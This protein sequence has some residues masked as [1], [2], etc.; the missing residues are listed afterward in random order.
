MTYVSLYRK[1]RS[2][3]FSDVMGQEHVTRT[4]QNAIKAQKIGHA[5]LFCGSRGTGKTTVARLLAKALNCEKGPTPE[6]CNECEACRAITDGTAVDVIEMD[7]ASH[8]SVDDIDALRDGVKYPPMLLRYKVYIIDEAHQLS[9]T[10]KDAF[11]KTL[12]E[13]PAHAVFILATTEAHE[14]P[15]TIRSRCQQFDFRRGTLQDISA[16]LRFVAESE[17]ASIDEEAVDTIARA[18]AGSWRDGLSLLEQVMAF[19]DQRITVR[20]VN[21]VLGTVERETL[22]EVADC[23]A[24]KDAAGAF[25]LA[26]KLIGE[27]RDVRELLRAIAGHFRDLLYAKARSS[28]EGPGEDG[29]YAARLWQQES[30]FTR[31]KL[32]AAVEIFSE[33]DRQTKWSDQHR[34]LLEMALLRAMEETMPSRSA[35]QAISV[36]EQKKPGESAARRPA[37]PPEPAARGARPAPAAPRRADER[38]AEQKSEGRQAE[39]QPDGEVTI[40]EVHSGWPS[41]V[42]IFKGSK[43][44]SL[45]PILSRG[46][47]LRVED[48]NMVVIGFPSDMGF[49]IHQVEQPRYREAVIKTFAHVLKKQV[50][51]KTETFTAEPESEPERPNEETEAIEPAADGSIMDAVL[52]VFPGSI[53][54]PE[55]LAAEG[56]LEKPW[57]DNEDAK[58]A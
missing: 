27:G 13:P 38:P 15:L 7:A 56:D 19:S 28:T 30:R 5:Y 20:D 57:E 24:E 17:G 9:P 39:E 37:E 43:D 33:A 3:T 47:P 51:L 49:H 26:E 40:E 36:E 8:R 41:V 23:I 50:R 45:F 44:A 55:E 46:K 58:D 12:E 10:A 2:Q 11:L 25:A 29:E 18:A 53:V 52:T 32:L 22:F 1:Y 14:I 54:D 42:R 31:Q 4:L 35:D 16:R 48:R 34:L 6:P 21:T